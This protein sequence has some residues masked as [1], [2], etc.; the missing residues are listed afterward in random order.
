MPNA[1]SIHSRS[2]VELLHSGVGG[3]ELDLVE[4]SSPKP[5]SP[6][7]PSDHTELITLL[8]TSNH[9]PIKVGLVAA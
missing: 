5:A 9:L 6:V 7:S 1:L 8:T 3:V 4:R 2:A